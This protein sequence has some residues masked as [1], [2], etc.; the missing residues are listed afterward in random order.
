[1]SKIY[2]EK[3]MEK[4]EQAQKESKKKKTVVK[5]IPLNEIDKNPDNDKVFNMK[6]IELLATSIDEE[7]FSGA[8]EVYKKPDGRYEISSGHR[9]YKAM[10]LLKRLTIPCIIKD[11]PSDFEKGKKL[12]LSNTL[13]RKLTPMD[14]ARAIDYYDK[15][16]TQA[17][18]KKNFIQQA[19][20]FFGLSYPQVYRF[21]CLLKIIPELQEMAND[22]NF[23]FSAFRSAA[24]LTEE[25]QKELYNQ[26]KYF[27][28]KPEDRREDEDELDVKEM[29][30]TRPRIEQIIDNIRMREEYQA[31]PLPKNKKEKREFIEDKTVLSKEIEKKFGISSIGNM[32]GYKD[33]AVKEEAVEEEATKSNQTNK[34]DDISETFNNAVPMEDKEHLKLYELLNTIFDI[35]N[36]KTL[37]SETLKSSIPYLENVLKVMKSNDK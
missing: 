13:N 30:L 9:R 20:K 35:V 15:L 32:N 25:G 28:V 7:G 36:S 34:N 26:L 17:G 21:Q 22:P 11:I 37:S 2:E 27:I 29:K 16:L 8:I 5:D 6:E 1:M 10:V 19:M 3:V 14:M 12:L 33:K 24:L 4:I 31:R 18:E 23:P